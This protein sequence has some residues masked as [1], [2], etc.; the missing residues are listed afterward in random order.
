MYLVKYRFSLIEENIKEYL[1]FLLDP[2][3]ST[4]DLSMFT[5][6]IT[7]DVTEFVTSRCQYLTTIK[8]GRY[9]ILHCI[10]N[11]L[12]VVMCLMIHLRAFV[13]RARS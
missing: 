3:L 12:V 4:L 9:F 10:D 6:R 13:E 2:Y 8:L 11:Q 7:N 5:H 1:T